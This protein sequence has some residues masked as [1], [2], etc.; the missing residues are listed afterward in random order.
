[1]DDIVILASMVEKE[2]GA[3]DFAKVAAVFYNRLKAGMTLSSDATVKYVTG[4]LSFDTYDTDFVEK[5]RSMDAERMVEL[6]QDAYDEYL[7]G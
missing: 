5:L 4:E 2:A 1:M 7:A 6:Y 3:E